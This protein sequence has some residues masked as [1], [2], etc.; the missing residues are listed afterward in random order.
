LDTGRI[1]TPDRVAE[2]LAVLE[3]AEKGM[4]PVPWVGCGGKRK[5][6]VV[7][8]RDDGPW[9][10]HPIAVLSAVP[11]MSREPDAKGIALMRNAAPALL[12]LAAAANNILDE[13]REC[14]HPELAAALDELAAA[15]LGP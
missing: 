6:G 14:W 11:T 12:K 8:A 2:A 13:R 10:S 15:V 9:G 7:A 5:Y 3:A 1:V 4:T